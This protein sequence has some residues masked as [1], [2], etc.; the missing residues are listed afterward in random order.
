M[1]STAARAMLYAMTYILKSVALMAYGVLLVAVSVAF[2]GVPAIVAVPLFLVPFAIAI[3][4]L[5]PSLI[6]ERAQRR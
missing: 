2:F 5:R 4:R 3:R 1:Q 6:A